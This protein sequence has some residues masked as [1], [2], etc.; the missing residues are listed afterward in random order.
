MDIVKNDPHVLCAVGNLI[1][2]MFVCVYICVLVV[3]GVW[4]YMCV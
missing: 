3:G 4:V 2:C 1:V